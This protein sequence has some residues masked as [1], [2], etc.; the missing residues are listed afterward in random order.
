MTTPTPIARRLGARKPSTLFAIVAAF[1][2]GVL[3]AALLVPERSDVLSA[4]A[5]TGNRSSS[6]SGDADDAFGTDGG[7]AGVDGGGG[8]SGGSSGTGRTASG[9]GAAGAGG[10]T[11]GRAASAARGGATAPGVTADTITIGFGLPDLGAIAALGPGYDQGDPHQHIEGILKQLRADGRLP[12]HGRDIKPVYSRY[13]ILSAEEQRATC[14][15]FGVDTTVFAVIAVHDFGPGNECTAREFKLPTFTSDGNADATYARSAPN[16]F[17]MQMSAD[18]LFRNFVAWADKD[19]LLTGKRIGVY[20]PSTPPEAAQVVKDTIINPIKARGHT[21]AAEVTTAEPAT[22]G[23]SDSVAVQRFSSQRVDTAILVVS[24]IA[25]TNFFNQAQTQG[26][27]PRYLDND[28]AFSTTDTATGTYPKDHFDGTP[29]F[30]GMR[31][32]E[33]NSGLAEPAE[34]A[35]CRAAIKKQTGN[36]IPRQGRD[37]EYIAANQSCDEI[38]TVLHGLEQAGPALTRATFILGV[39]TIRNRSAGIHGNLTFTPQRHDG[40]GSWRRI[41]WSKDC[42]CWKVKSNMAPLLT[43]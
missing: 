1:L 21:V 38:M 22:G 24:A 28:S 4:G 19:G 32:G 42:S 17:T 33:P 8:G 3:V 31:F 26:Y 15:A 10:S 5:A 34:A 12:V 39:E 6:G 7:E 13:N 23:P 43:D 18:R 37:A 35:W 40:G 2:F 29:A 16:M 27:R 14:E 9:S 11:G 36:D 25:K 30:T 20:Y 41:D